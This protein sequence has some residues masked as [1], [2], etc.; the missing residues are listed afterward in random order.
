MTSDTWK[1]YVKNKPKK[2]KPLSGLRVLEVCTIVF[3]PSGPSWL[4]EMGAEAIKVEIPPLGDLERDLSCS[5]F[6]FKEQSPLFLHDNVNK[7]YLGL[8]LHKPEGQ[9]I[10]CQLA[11][12]ADIIE[13]N[14]RPGVMERFNVDY[15]KIQKINPGIIYLEKNGFGQWGPYAEENRPSNDGAS[16]AFSGI[17]WMSTF[18][19]QTPIKQMIY[20]S[21]MYGALLA[22]VAVL[23]ALH[24]RDRTGKGQYIEISQTESIMRTMSWVWPYLDITGKNPPPAGNRD[25]SVCPADTFCCSDDSMVSLAAAAPLEF[26]GLCAAMGRP[27][28]AHDQRF[29]DHLTRLQ[30]ENATALLEIIAGWAA[31]HTAQ[32]IEALAREHGFAASRV[33][34]AAQ[35]MADRH[36]RQ[37]GFM[38]QMDDAM[39]GTYLDHEFPVMMSATPPQKKWAARA[40]GFDNEFLMKNLL[41]KSEEELKALYET[42][43]LGK[44]ADRPGRRPPPDWDGS[45]DLILSRDQTPA[46]AERGEK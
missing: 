18:P 13:N 46:Q 39:Y 20:L 7:Y 4:A 11:A 37:R 40:V 16:Q 8:D 22:E 41:N 14:L 28:L 6:R 19:G 34:D 25:V 45:S 21:D 36:T 43:A 10:F 23:S 1:D 29:A 9:E 17:A 12:K 33:R 44:W 30:E 15:R 38:T 35:V 24:H 31:Q 42:G 27:E 5:G 26:A 32:E 2:P 3:G